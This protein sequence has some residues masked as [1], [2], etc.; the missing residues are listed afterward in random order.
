M[1]SGQIAMIV[2]PLVM[3]SA[4]LVQ[5]S[6]PWFI[7]SCSGII[8]I[9]CMVYIACSPGGLNVGRVSGDEMNNLVLNVCSST[10]EIFNKQKS[11]KLNTR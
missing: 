3:S 7:S 11:T 9:S 5:Q 4:S 2:S 1:L 10:Q 6:L 8:V